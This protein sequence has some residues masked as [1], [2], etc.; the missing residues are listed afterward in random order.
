MKVR[1]IKKYYIDVYGAIT[2]DKIYDVLSVGKISNTPVYYL[3]KDNGFK[4]WVL[5]EY[6]ITIEEQRHNKLIEIGIK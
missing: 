6:F 4:D 2:K 3:T 5:Q 1:C